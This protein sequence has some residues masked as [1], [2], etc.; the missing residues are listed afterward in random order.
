M[1][2]NDKLFSQWDWVIVSLSSITALNP[3]KLKWPLSCIVLRVRQTAWVRLFCMQ[4]SFA[5]CLRIIVSILILYPNIPWI[6]E[7]C[8][9]ECG[10]GPST[11]SLKT[12]FKSLVPFSFKGACF[13]VTVAD[14]NDLA[15]RGE[16]LPVFKWHRKAFLLHT[17]IAVFP[18]RSQLCSPAVNCPSRC[19]ELETSYSIQLPAHKSFVM[20]S[21][22]V[23]CLCSECKADLL[24]CETC[25]YEDKNPLT[26]PRL[27][28]LPLKIT[29]VW[30]L[31]K[32]LLGSSG[33][34]LSLQVKQL[35]AR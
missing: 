33:V 28:P 34:P 4:S 1:L 7:T 15:T 17:V 21:C 5:V 13:C 14:R 29:V 32:L 25:P 31:R 2:T 6:Q 10:S 26:R 9:W 18:S 27:F 12:G 20:L 22:K 35:Q 19:T 30:L 24:A 11:D 23:T 3:H 8:M 16:N